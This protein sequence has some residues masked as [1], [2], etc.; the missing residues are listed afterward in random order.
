MQSE[1]RSSVE[2]ADRQRDTA[3]QRVLCR[4]EFAAQTLY[5]GARCIKKYK[6]S[7]MLLYPAPGS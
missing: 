2:R 6:I 3:A 7:T 1:S 5:P 4:V